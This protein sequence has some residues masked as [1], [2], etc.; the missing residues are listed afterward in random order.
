M[1]DGA[2][3]TMS[4]EKDLAVV[5]RFIAITQI[6]G[7]KH[8]MEFPTPNGH[9]HITSHG[10]GWAYEVHCNSTGDTLWFQD[11]NAYEIEYRTS[12]FKNEDAI[13]TYFELLCD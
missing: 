4:R 8:M 1:L 9:Y 2:N 6:D 5:R 3:Q 12:N 13:R 7:G 11:D 10:N